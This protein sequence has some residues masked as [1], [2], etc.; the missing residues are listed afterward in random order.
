MKVWNFARDWNPGK[1]RQPRKLFGIREISCLEKAET[2]TPKQ[3]Y[4]ICSIGL[5]LKQRVNFFER[6]RE[7]GHGFGEGTND[8]KT[9]RLFYK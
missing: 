4:T 7:V 8:A 9:P 2:F 6:E 1:G 5:C 3:M